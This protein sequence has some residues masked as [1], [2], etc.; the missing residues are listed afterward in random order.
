M[1]QKERVNR[2]EP[3]R[4]I[5]AIQFKQSERELLSKT[6]VFRNRLRSNRG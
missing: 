3:G 2:N 6:P 5:Q 4:F 1:L